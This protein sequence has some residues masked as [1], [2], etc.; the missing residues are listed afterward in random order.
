MKKIFLLFI[1]IYNFSFSIVD[2]QGINWGDNEKN[3]QLIFPKVIKEPSLNE[4]ITILA[5]PSPKDFVSKYQFFLKD[6]AL[7]KI[8]V[9]FDKESVGKR[10]L[11]DIYEQL[12]K[13]IGSPISKVPINKKIE[14]LTLKG[15]SLKFIP[16]ISTTVY[17][18]G[19]DTIN[20]Y[21]KMI[22]SN[23]YL[24]YVDSTIEYE[25]D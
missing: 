12:L 1:L 13:N 20:E 18:N 3:L 21:E 24:E 8:R 10:E 16:D 17:F 15:N 2:F 19:V 5:V 22:D 9:N 23:L 11:Q 14:T 6:N 4:N 7:Y 25:I